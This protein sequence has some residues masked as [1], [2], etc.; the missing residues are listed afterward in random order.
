MVKENQTFKKSGTRVC[1]V[2]KVDCGN[3]G[4]LHVPHWGKHE[5]CTTLQ[6]IN[7]AKNNF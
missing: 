3:L 2:I 4:M 1:K 7:Q 6:I 5:T